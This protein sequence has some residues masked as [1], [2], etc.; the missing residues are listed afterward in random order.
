MGV[1]REY[2]LHHLSRRIWAW[3]H[4]HGPAQRWRR[5]LGTDVAAAGADALFPTVTR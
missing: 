3:R 2:R 4:E 1:T 5:E